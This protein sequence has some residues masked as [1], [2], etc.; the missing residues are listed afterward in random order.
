MAGY[1]SIM[2]YFDNITMTGVDQTFYVDLVHINPET[3]A[4][5][6]TTPATITLEAIGIMNLTKI[7][8]QC[9]LLTPFLT[10]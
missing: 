3:G 6:E 7:T 5:I 9:L 1:N 8:G 4:N 10:I 2:L